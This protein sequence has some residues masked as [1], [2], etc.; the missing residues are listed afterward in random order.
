MLKRWGFSYTRPTYMLKRANG[1]KQEAFQ[2]ELAMIK[3]RVRQ[4]SLFI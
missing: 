4:V 3:K 1:K 2:K